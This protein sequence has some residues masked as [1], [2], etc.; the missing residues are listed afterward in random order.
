MPPPIHSNTRSAAAARLAALGFTSVRHAPVDFWRLTTHPPRFEVMVTNPPFSGDNIPRLL[1]FLEAR[2]EPWLLLLPEFVA[3]KTYFRD[4]LA[5]RRSGGAGGSG[6]PPILFLA[7][8]E[9]PY[10]FKAPPS[11]DGGAAGAGGGGGGLGGRTVA[12]GH[13]TCIWFCSG[14]PR[15]A[16]LGGQAADVAVAED[17]ADLPRLA[18]AGHVT[19]AE[20]RWRKKQRKLAE[21]GEG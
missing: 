7:P 10:A 3:A 5:R 17:V 13:F 16:L 4:L 19:P 11:I 8:R 14:I 2:D 15:E 12:S 6:R 21:A 9:A 20:R 1:A 18:P